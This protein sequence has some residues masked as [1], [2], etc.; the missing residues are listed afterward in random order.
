MN[1][2]LPI[3]QKEAM[4]YEDTKLYACLANYPI[5]KG[6]TIIVWKKTVQDLHL[7]SKNDYEYLMDKVNEVRN[8]LI[9]TFKI[10]KVYLTYLM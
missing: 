1:E 4:I 5:V 10:E 7:L 6:H 3:P 8:A 9:K 2:R